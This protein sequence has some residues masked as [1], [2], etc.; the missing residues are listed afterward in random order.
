[1]AFQLISKEIT[2]FGICDK[3]SQGAGT[4]KCRSIN[5]TVAESKISELEL[6]LTARLRYVENVLWLHILMSLTPV[7]LRKDIT[8][9]DVFGVNRIQKNLFDNAEAF[10][11]LLVQIR[12]DHMRNN[13]Q[14]RVTS[15]KNP[16][17]IPTCMNLQPAINIPAFSSSLGSHVDS[18]SL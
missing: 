1:V 5:N 11:L 10:Y 16:G 8:R 12:S 3:G 4:S 7:R 13:S 18:Y 9:C 2:S 17:L 6:I 15:L 14:C